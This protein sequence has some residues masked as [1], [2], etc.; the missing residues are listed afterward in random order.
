MRHSVPSQLRRHPTE[1]SA[2]DAEGSTS[3]RAGRSDSDV[4]VEPYCN[5]HGDPYGN[6]DDD[7]DQYGNVHAEPDRHAFEHRTT[8][9]HRDGDE[10]AREHR[11]EHADGDQHRRSHRHGAS[12]VHVD[13]DSNVH[14]VEHDR[15]R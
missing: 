11:D 10:H 14:A 5:L 12:Y 13:A 2:A 7:A 6:R 4:D 15:S 1:L 9:G 8:G 3:L